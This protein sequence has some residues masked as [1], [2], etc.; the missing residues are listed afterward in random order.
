[1][2]IDCSPPSTVKEKMLN[3]VADSNAHFKHQ[4]RGEPDL[5]CK[6]KLK[7]ALDILEQKPVTFLARFGEYLL[8]DDLTFF[9]PICKQYEVQFY[10]KEIR[11]RLDDRK[12]KQ[13][14]RNRRFEA[15]KKL[16]TDTDYFGDEEM[17]SRNP[18]LYEQL[19]G[20][21]LTKEEINQ[22]AEK[23]SPQLSEVFMQHLQSVKNS[24]LYETLKDTEVGLLLY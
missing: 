8:E 21:Y 11:K 24:E 14:I 12:N 15:M 5:S 9:E 4:Q 6:D 19:I 13:K 17:K 23:C 3:R 18:L 7:I 22:Q 2:E 20:Q 10:L 1:M 16:M